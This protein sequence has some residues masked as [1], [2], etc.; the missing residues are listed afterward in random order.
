[1]NN[2][3]RIELAGGAQFYEETFAIRAQWRQDDIARSARRGRRLPVSV[4][5]AMLDAQSAEF[6]LWLSMQHPI[7]REEVLKRQWQSLHEIAQLHRHTWEMVQ[8]ELAR[9]KAMGEDIDDDDE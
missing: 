5:L 7:R 8:E 3:D 6:W 9:R 4:L 1:M 2:L